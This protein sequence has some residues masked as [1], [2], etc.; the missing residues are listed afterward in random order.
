MVDQSLSVPLVGSDEGYGLSVDDLKGLFGQ[1]NIQDGT[2]YRALQNLGGME[3]VERKLVTSVQH[4]IDRGS[5]GD[6][7]RVF[8]DNKP[9]EKDPVTF[10]ELVCDALED[11]TLRILIGAACV[12]LIVGSIEDPTDGWLEG[13]AIL[14]AVVIVVSVTA[15]NDYLK[16]KQFRK[17]SAKAEEVTVT[18]VR[19]GKEE[20]ISTY[21]LVVGDLMKVATGSIIPADGL[22]LEAHMMKADE[23][24]KTGES[25]LVSKG[26]FKD[27]ARPKAS[28]F[29]L[30]GSKIE[31]GSGWMFVC[32][33]GA[34]S[35]TGQTEDLLQEE[36]EETPL[37][38]KLGKIADWIG[39]V[40]FYV[41][42]FTFMVL[43]VYVII[44]AFQ[45]GE[46][47]G[48]SWHG[49]IT[50]FII[51]VTIIV[52]AVP[53]G[54][55]LAVTLS[56]AYSVG[57]M[58]DENN[59]VRHLQACET[60]GGAT[61]VCTDKT[62]TLTQNRMSVVEFYAN[63]ANVEEVSISG[64]RDSEFRRLLISS[65]CLN[66]DA[67]LIAAN[68]PGE[69]DE[70]KGN[71]TEC[72]LIGLAKRWGTDY[73]AARRESPAL[74]RVPFDSKWKWM[75]TMANVRDKD[76]IMVKGASENV[77][78]LCQ[79]KYVDGEIVPIN[80]EDK[81]NLIDNVV[82]P[83]AKKQ[84]RTLA[85]AY[86]VGSFQPDYFFENDQPNASYITSD[87]ILLAVVGIKDPIRK[88]VPKAVRRV[89]KAGVKVRMVTGDNI[90]TAISIAKDC[91]ILAKNFERKPDEYV[92]MEG[93]QFEKLVGGLVEDKENGG[94]V[95]RDLF[96]FRRI[97]A[98]LS[99]LA[100]SSPEH[101]YI[102]VTGLKQM[103][104]V[105]AVT[106]DGS[107]DAPALKKSDV[108]FAMNIAGTQLAKDAADIILIDDNFASI[109]TALKWGRNIYDCIRKFI[110][111]QLTVNI[112]A[113]TMCFLG[114]VVLHHSPL[115]AVQMLWVNLIMDTFAALALATEPPSNE[116]LKRKPYGKKESIINAEMKRNILGASVYQVCWLL[117]LLFLGPQ[118]FGVK[119]GWDAKEWTQEDGRHFT[120]FFN[121]F[122]FMQVFNEINC[123]KLKSSEWNVFKGFF[124]NSLFLFIIVVT[125][126]GQLAIV[127]F[128]GAPLN[129]SQLTLEEHLYCLAIGA[130][131][132]VF[133]FLVKAVPATVCSGLKVGEE[134]ERKGGLSMQQILRRDTTK[135][136]K[137]ATA[138]LATA[139][140]MKTWH[141]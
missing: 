42:L 22:V 108:G 53:E 30:S 129:C 98:E 9:R 123:R 48:D 27:E 79:Y 45:Q 94:K 74:A 6:R 38:A 116:L 99:V 82:T 125:I 134:S 25:D 73:E 67:T 58:K 75:A 89:Q 78:Q 21:D 26:A 101:K 110:Q 28:P 71:R 120:I 14:C 16:D 33:V 18:V 109:V 5:V 84:L 130:G 112:T 70:Q 133:N 136:N 46:W 20:D 118:I 63:D 7:V 35:S 32:A 12:S 4:G 47:S 111:F 114:A 127:H 24:S 77:I 95:V 69:L 135:N 105:V 2:S 59:L 119:S 29:L 83:K 65:C 139:V 19:S 37:Q 51:A 49:L 23:S 86:K 54:L 93:S 56:L 50:S 60:M 43:V 122:V 140:R 15:T 97:A 141:R 1:S 90:E 124:N 34:N 91:G 92:V 115:T 44:D 117:I 17:L 137:M 3:A 40:G 131:C 81:K 138:T 13:V 128:G 11:T 106:G 36:S 62:G 103:D 88:E 100:R 64:V 8:G 52:V 102:L 39:T 61:D 57:K 85:L 41:A 104:R 96:Q 76:M 72:A 113:L 10:C 80:D 66:S 87:L 68:K 126:L 132:L 55:P 31:E 121:A 107:N